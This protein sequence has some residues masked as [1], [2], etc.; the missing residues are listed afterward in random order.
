MRSSAT[1]KMLARLLRHR[2]S[3]LPRAAYALRRGLGLLRPCL[4]LLPLPRSSARRDE[5][6]LAAR[7][8]DGRARAG[9]DPVD[10]DGAA[11]RRARPRRAPPRRRSLPRTS[12]APR[13]AAASTTSRRQQPSRSPTLTSA[14]SR[15]KGLVKP[16]FGR[17][18]CSGIWPPSKPSKR[19]LPERAFWPLPPR[20]AVL[21]RPEP[22]PR[23]T[24][25]RTLVA[26][27]GRLELV[28]SDMGVPFYPRCGAARYGALAR[29]RLARP[30]GRSGGR[31]VRRAPRLDAGADLAR[32][33]P[34]S[35]G[36]SG[37]SLVESDFFRPR[38]ATTGR[39]DAGHPGR[40]RAPASP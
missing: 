31:G 8:L 4:G 14:N 10:R 18:R 13:S 16:N 2:A 33:S 15:R 17:R 22:W 6:H 25:L 29:L 36:V 9:G 12:P 19:M 39:C 21:P 20:P 34:W 3:R 27:S 1:R 35:A 5:L 32:S 24:R 37:R 28:Q 23:P 7:L 30:C 26:P 40:A 38:P 11:C